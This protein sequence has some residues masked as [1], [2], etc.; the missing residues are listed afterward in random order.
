MTKDHTVGSHSDD[1]G[2]DSDR[3]CR[4][5]DNNKHPLGG[6]ADFFKGSA[7]P[8]VTILEDWNQD[9]DGRIWYRW[10]LASEKDWHFK[11]T[12]YKQKP[13]VQY[14]YIST[15]ELRQR[16]MPWYRKLIYKYNTRSTKRRG[17]N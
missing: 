16:A 7:P 6:I 2:G 15:E 10:K 4:C 11:L 5:E 8:R 1:R 17:N 12:P 3:R 14:K 13:Y 9:S